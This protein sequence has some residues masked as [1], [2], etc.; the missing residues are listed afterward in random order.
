MVRVSWFAVALLWEPHA[1]V[2]FP[3]TDHDRGTES[4]DRG[5]PGLGGNPGVGAGA[6]VGTENVRL[7]YLILI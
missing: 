6:L 4:Y 5:L 3:G 2:S 1:Q 7:H